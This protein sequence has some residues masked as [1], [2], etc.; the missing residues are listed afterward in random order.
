MRMHRKLL[1][2]AMVGF[3]TLALTQTTQPGTSTGSA[4]GTAIRS[5][6]TT[7]FPPIGT[8][9]NAIW[10]VG[11]NGNKNKATATQAITPLKQSANQ[12]F[13]QLDALTHDLD[14]VTTFL[15]ATVVA[16]N[17]VVAMRT[18][19]YGK[20]SLN[21]DEKLRLKNAMTPAQNR[22]E[23]LAAADSVVNAINDPTLQT[24]LRAIVNANAGV[25]SSV[26]NDYDAGAVG[27]ADLS[28]QLATLD[29]QLSA[30][31]ALSTE[32]ISNV[33]LG[34]KAARQQSSG[35]MGNV[36]ATVQDNAA[37]DLTDVLKQH[38][39]ALK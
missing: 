13:Q 38:Y 31:N 15:A 20:S 14:A 3:T 5:A 8:I 24:S 16:E 25:L 19:I 10:P 7:A 12:G 23:K 39:P 36:D 11:Q 28:Q 22:L 35:A 1:T 27:L 33:S 2:A 21:D 4:I 29:A 26:K 18:I 37:K 34:L 32:I 30:V 17:N 6:I 9:L